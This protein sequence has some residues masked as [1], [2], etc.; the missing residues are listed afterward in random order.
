MN[1]PKNKK[2]TSVWVIAFGELFNI[3]LVWVRNITKCLMIIL[4]RF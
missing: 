2:L 4:F 1:P 3:P